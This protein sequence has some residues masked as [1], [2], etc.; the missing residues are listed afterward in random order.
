MNDRDNDHVE[1]HELTGFASGDLLG[2]F[3][4]VETAAEATHCRQPFF[5]VSLNPPKGHNPGVDDFETAAD[6]IEAKFP[7][8]KGQPRT[9]IFH[10]KEGRRHAHAVWSRID[11]ERN[12][13]AQ[14]SHSKEKLRDVSRAMYAAMGMQAPAGIQQRNRRDPLNYDIHTWQQAKRLGEDPRDLKKIIQEAWAF[15]DDRASFER[16]L[17]QNALTLARGDK[18]GFVIVHHSGEPM[19]LTRYGG[20]GTRD[21]KA[22]LGDP[23]RL[24]TLDQVRSMLRD[25]MSAAADR[26]GHA[27][28]ERHRAEFRPLTGEL[29][30]MKEKHREERREV[31]RKQAD[32]GRQEARERAGRLRTGIMGLWDRLSGK[33]GKVSELNAR[34]AAAAKVRNRAER[35]AVVEAQMQERGELQGRMMQMRERHRRDRQHHRAELAVMLS[36]AN[37]DTRQTFTDHAREIEDRQK[38]TPQQR[39]RDRA[40]ARGT[41]PVIAASD[42]K[43]SQRGGEPESSPPVPSQGQAVEPGYLSG[44]FPPPGNEQAPT[45]QPE[46]THEAKK[47]ETEEERQ[48]AINAERERL[49]A[50]DREHQRDNDDPGREIN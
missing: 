36:M 10:E 37:E 35:H 33:R 25:R 3:L 49:E 17:E 1:L 42:R 16:A 18:R 29:H 43:G 44:Q 45:A 23:E 31:D 11:T 47:P 26:R 50:Q 38:R 28:R 19:S 20:L 6:L 15:S 12:R 32:R 46:A 9:L 14:L 7:D 21:L 40:E 2:A 22:R 39:R 4:E 41:M 34:E 30:S 8:L 48:A 5:S 13:A 27:M 24:P